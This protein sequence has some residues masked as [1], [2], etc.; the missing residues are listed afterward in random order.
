MDS[1]ELYKNLCDI[2]LKYIKPY[3]YESYEEFMNLIAKKSY[4][5]EIRR[6]DIYLI[7]DVYFWIKFA[8]N[9]L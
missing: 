3:D 1:Y 7:R 8:K 6:N 4:Y 9:P 5:S 2:A